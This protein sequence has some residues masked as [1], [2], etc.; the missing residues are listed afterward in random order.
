MQTERTAPPRQ[1]RGRSTRPAYACASPRHQRKTSL[2]ATCGIVLLGT[3][4]VLSGCSRKSE[5]TG[6]PTAT[7]PK[8]APPAPLSTW[9]ADEPVALVHTKSA[10]I[11][12]AIRT[13]RVRPLWPRAATWVF[14]DP[15]LDLL[16]IQ[17]NDE[18]HVVDLRADKDEATLIASG[19]PPGVPIGITRRTPTGS[20]A[21][22][23]PSGCDSGR[24]L[25]LDWAQAPRCRYLDEHT[26]GWI[27]PHGT[28]LQGRAWLLA[29]LTRGAGPA[30]VTRRDF[31]FG[32]GQQLGA[33]AGRGAQCSSE[34]CGRPIDFDGTGVTLV[35]T[36]FE[37]GDCQ[38]L[39]CHLHDP[40]T[41]KFATPPVAASW[42]DLDSV[43]S[44]PCG[45]YHFDRSGRRFLIGGRQ[46]SV[47]GVCEPIGGEGVGWLSGGVDVGASG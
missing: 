9:A 33:I 22:T 43:A 47:G 10:V 27:E 24:T 31:P 44:G 42:G 6:T 3:A 34:V 30:D 4:A 5:S 46:C 41:K 21:S 16:W 36:R 38:H 17:T 32:Q 19:L 12:L 1:N 18:V 39:A 45:V 35:V 8:A 28:T 37:Q 11:A 7:R 40:S 25:L 29:Q 13:G 20:H 26:A 2:A 14:H 23:S 15:K